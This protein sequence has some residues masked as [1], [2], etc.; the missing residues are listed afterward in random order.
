MFQECFN[1]IKFKEHLTEKGLIKLVNLKASLNLGLSEKLKESF[2]SI[3][4]N[5][6]K[7]P[8]TIE[9]LDPYWVAGFTSGDGSF[10]VK[11][12]NSTTKLGTRIQL[13]FSIPRGIPPGILGDPRRG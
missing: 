13:R 4:A 2:P 12:S 5:K 6:I 3:V 9:N 11:T 10:H 7:N 8:I 1:I